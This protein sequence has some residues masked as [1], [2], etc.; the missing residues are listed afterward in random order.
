MTIGIAAHGPNAGLAVIEGLMQA[1]RTARG[2]IGGFVSF[3][4]ITSD[5]HLIRLE[6]QSGGA[7][8]LWTQNDIAAAGKA[9]TAVLMSSGPNRPA[10]LSQFTPGHPQL[11]LVTGHRFPNATGPRGK[12]LNVQVLD[13]LARRVD[14]ATA[15]DLVVA[16]NPA[17]DA[18]LLAVSPRGDLHL[19]NTA[20]VDS[21]PDIGRAS[22]R[23]FKDDTVC[24]GVMHNAIKPCGGLA[25]CVAETVMGVMEPTDVAFSLEL[26]QGQKVVIAA[27]NSIRSDGQDLVIGVSNPHFIAGRCDLG[28]GPLAKVFDG[29]AEIGVA[30]YEPYLTVV[31]GRLESIDGEQ[32]LAIP[33]GPAS[34]R[35]E[36]S[37]PGDRPVSR[38]G[39]DVLGD[40]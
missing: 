20:Y 1:E 7:A 3:A 30:L 25:L 23:S 35:P 8:E 29:A 31:D 38:R 34:G 17:A 15:L 11:G 6:T 32:R 40:E 5:G 2:A 27:Q 36:L 13:L 24:C 37:D 28:L 16:A 22:L 12:A 21:F 14:L 33:I 19:A 39:Y 26:R 18:G 9:T 4:A 10:P